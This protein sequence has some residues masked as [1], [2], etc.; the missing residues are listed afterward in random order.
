MNLSD[1]N[2][3]IRLAMH[4]EIVAPG[5]INRRII[6]DYELIYIADGEFTLMYNEKEYHCKKGDI[7]LLCPNIPHSFKVEKVNVIQP[8]IHFDIKYDS[9]S[10]KVFINFRDY[11]ALT[12]AE[13][14]MIRKNIFLHLQNRPIIRM[15]NQK[16]FLKQFY[17][18]IDAKDYRSLSAKANMLRILEMII[19]E[20]APNEFVY[21]PIPSNV[22]ALVK[23][24]I[25][26]NYQQKI[27]LCDLER[28]F[29]YSKYYIEKLFKQEYGISVINY[30]NQKRM[31]EACMLL[32]EYSVSK[33]SQLLGYS[34]IYAFSRAFRLVYGT[35]PSKYEKESGI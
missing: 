28:Q 13:Y 3:Y 24:Y 1:I 17:E 4:S 29:G 7:L 26:S 33:T 16:E 21:T 32:K 23:S 20:N 10:E 35:S 25:D 34:S 30:Y 12:A 6:F 19:T 22:A 11:P 15:T 27:Q 9:Y 5:Y 8:H 18:I 31:E 14:P 2:P